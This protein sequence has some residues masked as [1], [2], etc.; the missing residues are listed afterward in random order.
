M[1]VEQTMYR[2]YSHTWRLILIVCS[3]ISVVFASN[4]INATGK[5]EVY[6]SSNVESVNVLE[7]PD[8]YTTIK[9]ASSGDL[10]QD[11]ERSL[12]KFDEKLLR[13]L[14]QAQQERQESA[15]QKAALRS[16]AELDGESESNAGDDASEE[17]SEDIG[18]SNKTVDSGGQEG[19]SEGG[20]PDQTQTSNSVDPVESTSPVEEGSATAPKATIPDGDDNDVI[21]RQLREAAEAETDP[22]VKEKLWAEYRKYKNQQ[23]PIAAPAAP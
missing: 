1:N 2:Q 11:L 4:P 15:R 7:L 10:E 16:D 22:K 21:A 12:Q 9:S 20:L 5:S 8:S 14:E 13:E 19:S 18:K 6:N 17:S 23:S 3:G